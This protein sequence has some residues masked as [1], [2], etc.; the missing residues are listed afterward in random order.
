MDI[1]EK[2]PNKP[3]DWEYISMNPNITMEFIEKNKKEISFQHLS[4][5]KFDNNTK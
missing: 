1:I 4:R 5:N 3:W 2:Y